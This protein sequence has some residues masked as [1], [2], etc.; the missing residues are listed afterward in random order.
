MKV[1]NR[2]GFVDAL[3]GYA[4]ILVIV[5]HS[6]QSNSVN[7]DEN[8]IFR[9][10]YSFHM[11]LFMFLSGFVLWLQR[12]KINY[13][14]LLKRSMTLV[15]PF[16]TV[17]I[18]NYFLTSSF[19]QFS[20]LMYLRDLV[21]A[22]DLGV[23]FLWTLFLNYLLF[24][25][26]YKL[27]YSLKLEKYEEIIMLVFSLILYYLPLS[28]FG[29]TFVRW[30]FFFF[31]IGYLLGKNY[32]L[33]R[34]YRNKIELIGIILFPIFVFGWYRT[35]NSS[36]ITW[37]LSENILF[38][39]AHSQFLLTLFNYAVP[40]L[41]IV[42]SIVIIK[43]FLH[44]SRNVYNVFIELGKYTLDI[45]VIQYLIFFGGAKA[46]LFF[47]KPKGNI[48]IIALTACV[49]LLFSYSVSKFILRKHRVSRL[50]LG[51]YK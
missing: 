11:P 34:K 4:I 10:I 35:G 18:L 6:I 21:V 7:F 22:P 42:F 32:R 25:A 33:I 26:I 19:H 51:I 20:L 48:L 40:I 2:N 3:K 29:F 31:M 9:I 43:K 46:L 30:Y 5:G 17:Y 1:G 28:T 14:Y 47:L 8:I 13:I 38:F 16:F 49:V 15:I 24:F 50:L 12:A 23:W 44:Y 36:Y 41:G 39:S 37:L 45:Y 27:I